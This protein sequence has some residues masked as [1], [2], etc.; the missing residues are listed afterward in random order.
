MDEPLSRGKFRR[1]AAPDPSPSIAER[2]KFGKLRFR[3]G[4]FLSAAA[5]A[6]AALVSRTTSGIVSVMKISEKDTPDSN[7]G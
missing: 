7:T 1:I 3:K 2:G 6:I 5:A 4:V